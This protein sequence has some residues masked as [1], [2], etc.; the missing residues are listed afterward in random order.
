MN[1]HIRSVHEG[2]KQFKCE[3]CD[4]SFTNKH[5]LKGHSASVHGE[6]A[7]KNRICEANF[8]Q[9]GPFKNMGKKKLI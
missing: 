8:G 1:I 3:M 6:K 7:I 5:N 9:E 2:K 4:K